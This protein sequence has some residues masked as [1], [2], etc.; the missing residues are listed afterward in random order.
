MPR[1]RV[2]TGSTRGSWS[3]SSTTAGGPTRSSARSRHQ[4]PGGPRAGQEARSAG[5]DHRLRRPG[6]GRG[7]G[8]GVLA[9]TWVTQAPGTIA[10][11]LTGDFGAI[12][13]I[14][15]CHH[16]TGE[17][18]Y[19]LKMRARDTR[20]LERVI[21]SIQATRH[22]FSTETDV[23]FSTAFEGR[24]TGPRSRPRSSVGRGAARAG[25]AA[26]RPAP[27]LKV[28][29]RLHGAPRPRRRF[30]G[31]PRSV[32]RRDA[33]PGPWRLRPAG[34]RSARGDRA[35]A[36]A[37]TPGARGGPPRR[38]EALRLPVAGQ[39]GGDP[40]GLGRQ[41][42]FVDV[43]IAT[44]AVE[45]DDRNEPAA[46]HQPDE[47]QPPLELGHQRWP[48]VRRIGASLRAIVPTV[49]RRYTPRR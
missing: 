18:D 36:G 20:D 32:R 7:V 37:C 24:P 25:R 45:E 39:A 46:G 41:L 13:E 43:R 1:K 22:V 23:V 38:R 49:P 44:G 30:A 33:A 35:A 31:G 6:L 9:F 11:D 48:G 47:Q 42:R 28:R 14:E 27:R 12:P 5:R 8:L 34:G 26:G 4:R 16:I 15:E 2:R 10:T 17:A 29:P 21:R 3:C 40:L 19:L